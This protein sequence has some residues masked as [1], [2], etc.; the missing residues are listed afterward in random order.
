MTLIRPP[1]LFC[2]VNRWLRVLIDERRSKVQ[3]EHTER[4]GIWVVSVDA[5]QVD[6]DADHCTKDEASFV[7][8]RR[9]HGVCNDEKCPEHG[10]ATK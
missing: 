9:T 6:K 2:P 3:Q 8:Y 4:D 5:D 10:G 1:P 7:R